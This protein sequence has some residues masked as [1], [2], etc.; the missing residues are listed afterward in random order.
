MAGESDGGMPWGDVD[1]ITAD[2]PNAL[3]GRRV[4]VMGLGVLGGGVS[5]ARY[6][7]GQGA[8]VTVTDLRPAEQLASSIAQLDGLPIRYVLG[9]HDT[10]DFLAADVVVRNPNVRRDSPYLAAAREAGKRVEM[11]IAWFFRACPGRIAGVTGTRGK[12][13]TTTLL[14]AMLNEAGLRP[15]LGG[16]LGGI[17]TLALLPAMTPDRWVVLELGNWMLEGLHTIRR[18]PQVAVFTNLLPDHLN[19]YDSMEDYGAAK[20]SIFRYQGAGDIAIF[21]ADNAY[22]ARYATEAPSGEVWLYGPDRLAS[23]RRETPDDV[24]AFGYGDAICLRGA[25]N[26]G[27]VQAAAL[28]AERIG[29][30]PE[31]IRRTIAGFGP[32]EHRLEELRELDGVLYVNDSASTA[33]VAGI[34]ALRS[35]DRPIVLIAGGNSKNLDFTEF[36][37]L[38]AERARHVIVLAGNA[39]D[40][41][42]EAVRAEAE[43]RGRG[44][45]VSGPTSDFTAAVAEARGRA[46]PGDVVLLSPGFTSFGMFRNEFDRGNQFRALVRA[47][48]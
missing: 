22:T 30:A 36:A 5:A 19:A 15:L 10:S 43:Q 20:S 16:N 21:N 45:I 38:A 27:N 8:K 24:H 39:S 33:P 26:V 29:I 3:R 17:E 25:H 7:V 13:T 11:E 9:Q 18:S 46:M 44:A 2:D 14:H 31:V 47:L 34:A 6:A 42:I 48:E 1:G 32:V 37:A 41:F 12:S 23:W 4:L 40:A 28:A 35:F